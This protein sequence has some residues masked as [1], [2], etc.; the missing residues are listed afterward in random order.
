MLYPAHI[1][2]QKKQNRVHVL[3]RLR[4]YTVKTRLLLKH[5]LR[6]MLISYFKYKLRVHI[7]IIL[8]LNSMHPQQ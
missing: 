5:A 8:S 6:K 2:S 3:S 4:K 7:T 1:A